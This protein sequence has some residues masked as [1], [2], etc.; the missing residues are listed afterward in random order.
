MNAHNQKNKYAVIFICWLI[1]CVNQT[2]ARNI[3]ED[4]SAANVNKP[5]EHELLKTDSSYHH[6][7][8]QYRDNYYGEPLKAIEYLQ[9]KRVHFE[10]PTEQ[11]YFTD[12]IKLIE[13]FFK[14][15]QYAQAENIL[16]PLAIEFKNKL[17]FHP[18]L[19]LVKAH[20]MLH[21]R[22]IDDFLETLQPYVSVYQKAGN[23][24]FNACYLF[25]LGAY[26]IRKNQFS[27][28]F[29]HLTSGLE[30]AKGLGI[31]HLEIEIRNQL[32]Q[33]FYYT[34]RY[35]KALNLNEEIIDI[36]RANDDRY[37]ET[38]ALSNKMNLYYSRA[39]YLANSMP[40]ED[41]ANNPIYRSYIKK[42]RQLQKQ[43]YQLAKEIGAYRTMIKAL[44]LKQSHSFGDNNFQQAII[45]GKEIS[46]IARQFGFD[47]ENAVASNNTAIA[48]RALGE[49]DKSIQALAV[50]EKSYL[51]M[52]NLQS[53]TWIYDDYAR[54]YEESGNFEKA[55]A[56]FKKFHDASMK[57]SQKTN[58]ETL[59]ELQ[60]KY[61]ANERSQEILRLTQKSALNTQ[62]LETE[63]MGRW[64][65]SVI[66]MAVFLIALTLFHKRKR[67]KRLLKNEAALN[68]K[69]TEANAAKQRFFAN[70]SH[71]F[72]TALTLSIGPLKK[73]IAEPNY[74]K[75]PFIESALE[76]NLHMM[77][78]I[79]EV[80]HIEKIGA[81]TL[82]MQI[83]K[84]N[85]RMA[86]N[87]CLNRFLLQFKEKRINICQHGFDESIYFYFDPSHL[88]KIVANILSNAAKYCLGDCTIELSVKVE[89][90]RINL[91]ICDDG[92]GIDEAEL[93]HIFERFYQG[94]SS[95]DQTLPGTGIGLSMVKELVEL[96]QGS[97]KMCSQVGK[98]CCV[99][100]SFKRG[101]SH[102][103]Q[104]LI[105]DARSQ[106]ET[107]PRIA[108]NDRKLP[109]PQNL[110]RHPTPLS[111]NAGHTNELLDNQHRKVILVVDDNPQIR[112]L[113]KSILQPEFH[114]VEADNG[115]QGLELAETIQPDLL[116]TDVMMP[117]MNG[118]Q[119][120]EH[121]REHPQLSH[122]SII[123]LTALSETE[124][125]V[126]G[127][128]LGADDYITKPF[129]NE[130]LKARVKG[131]L[132]QKQRLSKLL[133]KKYQSGLEKQQLSQ[134]FEGQD[135]KRSKQLE[136]L[137]AKNLSQCEFDVE[138]MYTAMNMTR[139]S[140]YRYTQKH[141]GCSPKHL[142]KVRRL[143]IAY[144]M[145]TDLQ[146]TISEVA[147]AVGYQSLSAFSRAF[148][149][150]FN[151]PPTQVKQQYSNEPKVE[152]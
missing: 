73:L 87:H 15:E 55:L 43:V 56:Y 16:G 71:E 44:I 54:T 150:H 63:K 11:A 80:L 58:N 53:L 152:V 75:N 118:F 102:Y 94:K 119:L 116:I 83:T 20:L 23:E 33:L 86:I 142:L 32:V 24:S 127:L 128:V 22:N 10:Y 67:L 112:L 97:V 48:Y 38:L 110:K 79:N 111:R 7:S 77:T 123:L 121:L 140:L 104:Q 145:L 146:G 69:I 51:E 113:I 108:A 39:V 82:P 34:Q 4:A 72:R 25:L 143:E 107:T 149:E 47:Y 81:K 139:S 50:A 115:K 109:I 17:Q 2:T 114:V 103:P 90:E 105:V 131:H 59:L 40:G 29:T 37:S 18:K 89:Q 92:P 31:T 9:K 126:H 52:D 125:R 68:Q 13:L 5:A 129:D 62:Q 122:L 64:L 136:K 88:E 30:N 57:F 133:L 134:T 138:Q 101:K 135:S 42:S 12:Q 49:Y 98:G 144:Q 84:I 65:L 36:A 21:N 46:E 19:A 70:I 91:E 60:E 141:Y 117:L 35:E 132:A 124:Q 28:A 8:Y 66:L 130:E 106:H 45:A 137:I 61:A 85:L 93:P 96:H 74:S 27:N 148:R 41:V 99:T 76:N 147:Y 14:T 100:I 78:L 120:T 1:L 6:I 151:H 95:S 3:N 26:E